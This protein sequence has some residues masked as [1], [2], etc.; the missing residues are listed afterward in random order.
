MIELFIIAIKK[1]ISK[2]NLIC[3]LFNLNELTRNFYFEF[4]KIQKNMMA[5]SFSWTIIFFFVV[6]AVA[7]LENYMD[8]GSEFF[9]FFP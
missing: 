1:Y 8:Y 4:Q 5:K 6:S 9:F 3:I 7:A 2:I